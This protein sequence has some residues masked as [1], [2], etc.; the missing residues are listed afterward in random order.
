MAELDDIHPR[1]ILL[2][3]F[4]KPMNISAYR[5]SMDTEIPQTRVSQI[6]KGKRR[7]TSDTALRLSAYFGNKAKFWLGLQ[8]DYD[9]E[10][11]LH[12]KRIYSAESS[13]RRNP[14]PVRHLSINRKLLKNCFGKCL[15]Q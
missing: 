14:L 5:L 7:I 9:I 12:Y 8:N 6:I 2:E 3:E 13:K 11:E 1:E 4:L 15:L 10:D